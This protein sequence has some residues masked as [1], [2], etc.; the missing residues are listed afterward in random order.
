VGADQPHGA[1]GQPPPAEAGVQEVA[2]LASALFAIDALQGDRARRRVATGRPDRELEP[3]LL[4]G[5][6]GGQGEEEPRV[7]ARVG[8]RD[9]GEA[10]DVR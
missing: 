9:P 2:D 6:L 7:L 1:G 3:G 8:R 5:L 10:R 4:A